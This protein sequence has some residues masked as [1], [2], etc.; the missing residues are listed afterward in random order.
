M[1]LTAVPFGLAIGLALGMV[2]GGG[3][4]LAVPI[5]VYVLGQTVHEATTS[6]LMVVT[7]G[8]LSGSFGHAQ[9]GRICWRHA[10]AFTVSAVPGVFIG[11][12][13]G[14]A[15][16]GTALILGF[17]FVML[18]AAAAI[19]RRA[20]G[21]RKDADPPELACPPLRI[22]LG[23][24]SG[25]IVGAMTGFF[26]VGGGFLIVPALTIFLALSMRLAVGTSLA[27]IA[28]TSLIALLSHLLTGGT[29]DVGVTAAMTLSAVIGALFG[30]TL[31]GRLPQSK[32]AK[33]FA[34]LVISLSAYLFVSAAF[35]GGPPGS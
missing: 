8:A 23:L 10:L 26:G 35:L 12:A 14:N 13:L 11:T 34:G 7:V 4:I 32:L 20:G 22:G 2:G 9:G 15:V 31:T 33:G 28:A 19:W 16:S 24:A 27:V 29:V 6:S 5:L 30:S 1:A 25:V 21:K 17:A 3:S 18:G